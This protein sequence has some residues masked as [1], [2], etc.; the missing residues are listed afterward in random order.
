MRV[1]PAEL[2]ALIH[3]HLVSMPAAAQAGLGTL[4]V[5]V[6]LENGDDESRDAEIHGGLFLSMPYISADKESLR[7]LMAH[8]RDSFVGTETM[9]VAVGEDEEVSAFDDAEAGTRLL[10]LL[11]SLTITPR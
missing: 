1:E 9:H 2:E 7:K 8:L 6:A 4:F 11:S 5:K 10:N 3:R